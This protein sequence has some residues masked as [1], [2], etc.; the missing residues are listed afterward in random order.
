MRS[1]I[2]FC[3]F[4]WLAGWLVVLVF[5]PVNMQQEKIKIFLLLY[6]ILFQCFIKFKLSAVKTLISCELHFSNVL[7][8]CSL[9]PQNLL[10]YTA[11]VH[12]KVFFINNAQ[13]FLISAK[14]SA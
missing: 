11:D 9:A 6:E 12:S 13:N 3:Y 14:H 2:V 7:I 10:L 1:L 8:N 5:F 4:F